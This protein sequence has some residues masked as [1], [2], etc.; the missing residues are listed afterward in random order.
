M[1]R[2]RLEISIC[3]QDAKGEKRY[4][5]RIGNLWIDTD[6]MN[7]NIDLPPGVSISGGNHYVNVAP[8][9]E[10]DGGSQRGQR[11]QGR[12]QRGYGGYPSTRG[13]EDDGPHGADDDIPF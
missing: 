3:Y 10:R 2:Q 4:V 9:M 13:A 5:N 7:G 6:T 12:Q 8:P 1:A 11:S